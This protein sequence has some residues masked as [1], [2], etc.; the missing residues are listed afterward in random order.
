MKKIKLDKIPSIFR[1]VNLPDEVYM[2][3]K[4]PA[5]EGAFIV[6]QALENI[7]KNDI[8]EFVEGRLGKLIEGDIIPAVLGYRKAPVEFAGAI[9]EK[10]KIGDELFLICESGL[11]GELLG[12]YEAWGKPM[13][14]KVLG[15]VVDKKGNNLNLRNYKLPY[16][17]P[18]EK[19]IPLLCIL[20]T[21]MDS[22]K[23]TM[24]CRIAHQLKVAGKRVAAVKVTGVAFT[25]D[26]YKLRDHGVDPVLDF[27][28]MGL[29]STC[30]GNVEIVVEATQN[31][32]NH[33]KLTDPDLIILE[34]GEGILGEYHNMDILASEFIKR[35]IGFVILAAN[36][37]AGIYG[38]KQILQKSGL[39][40]DLV[41]GPVAN[42]KIGVELIAKYFQLD[43]E[44]NQ[45]E[46][47]KTVE[48]INRKVFLLK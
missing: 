13:K 47:H 46:I 42:S 41:T 9:P 22:G 37:F 12:A 15:A 34:F 24:A 19:P 1:R 38:A 25:Q 23:T 20:S 39:S 17:K 2:D 45:H 5:E 48:L 14:V 3:G 35:E 32:I 43:A 7:D 8:L 33:A 36:D 44:S 28:D 26:P 29:P 6:V 11:V 40:I 4:I 21:R 10:V 18:I 30:S 27:V 16:L 31:L